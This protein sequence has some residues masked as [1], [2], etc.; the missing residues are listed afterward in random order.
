MI[1]D[2]T[3][4][5]DGGGL[6]LVDKPLG[7]TSHDAVN[8]IRGAM[9]SVV[10]RRNFKVGHAGTLDPLASGLL[11]IGYGPGTKELQALTGLEKTYVGTITLG[12]TTPSY[13][14]ETEPEPAGPW[15]HL[16]EV[17]INAAFAGFRGKSMQR[18]PNFSAKRVEGERAYWMARDPERAEAVEI[19]AREVHILALEIISITGPEV[20]FE[21]RV[22]K[23]T[24]I[25]S[26]AH[27]IGQ[28]LGCGAYLSALRRTAIGPYRVENAFPPV[29]WSQHIAPVINR[30]S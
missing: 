27:D 29:E 5:P 11:I 12:A 16:D 7:W 21:A 20:Q 15:E 19:P 6:I 30:G 13:D 17:A 9:R 14:R 28:A 18:P 2:H 4:D 23:G 22:S 8:K 10:K 26:L 24:Y 25:R 1:T 3:F